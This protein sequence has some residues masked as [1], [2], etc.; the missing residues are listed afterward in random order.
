MSTDNASMLVPR[1]H[2]RRVALAVR[3]ASP[4]VRVNE[5]AAEAEI[6]EHAAA[7]T[8]NTLE[9]VKIERELLREELELEADRITGHAELEKTRAEAD[10]MLSNLERA[11]L[12]PELAAGDTVRARRGEMGLS[13]VGL[14][15][16]SGVPVRKVADVE[17]GRGGMDVDLRRIARVLDLDYMPAQFTRPDR[18]ARQLSSS[19]S[20]V[21]EVGEA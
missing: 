5:A 18:A 7:L 2:R 1:R 20:S 10:T 12:N 11:R 6:A 21:L 9:R 14:A 19:P 16:R 8:R 3:A 17:A 4:E 15:D 13:Q